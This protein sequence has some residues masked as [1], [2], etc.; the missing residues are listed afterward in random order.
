MGWFDK[1]ENQ[2]GALTGRLAADVPM[3][4]NIVG[5]QLSSMLEMIVLL[6]ISLAI[7]FYYSWRISV[8][9]LI[10]SSVLIIAG[11]FEVGVTLFAFLQRCLDV[12]LHSNMTLWNLIQFNLTL[13]HYPKKCHLST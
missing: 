8:V 2:A 4:Q 10:F 9:S 11:A 12:W 6:V 1:L 3:L 13:F 7:A 5:R